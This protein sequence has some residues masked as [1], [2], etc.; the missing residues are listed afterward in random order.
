MVTANQEMAVYCFDTLLAHY[1]NQLVPPPAFDEGQ[2]YI[3]LS[4]LSL[5]INILVYLVC[6]YS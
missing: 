4:P 6:V 5:P 2:L 3:F 1:N